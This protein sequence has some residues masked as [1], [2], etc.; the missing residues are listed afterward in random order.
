MK[1]AANECESRADARKG[2]TASL[3]RPRPYYDALTHRDR[4]E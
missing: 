1:Y 2:P 4:I 3:H